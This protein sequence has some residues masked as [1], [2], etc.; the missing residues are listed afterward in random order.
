[1][2][3]IK[4]GQF[5]PTNE[6]LSAVPPIPDIW[7]GLHSNESCSVPGLREGLNY[8]EGVIVDGSNEAEEGKENGWSRCYWR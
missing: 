4:T 5:D 7:L 2:R 1:M 3:W 8:K 6:D